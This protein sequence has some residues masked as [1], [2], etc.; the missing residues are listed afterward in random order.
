M[1]SVIRGLDDFGRAVS[2]DYHPFLVCCHM[3]PPPAPA[4]MAA[5]ALWSLL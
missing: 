2:G 5:C 1:R 4:A 3:V